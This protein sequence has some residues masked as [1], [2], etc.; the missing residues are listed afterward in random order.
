MYDSSLCDEEVIDID[1]T[2]FTW[3]LL[4]LILLII[5]LDYFFLQSNVMPIHEKNLVLKDGGK[6]L[7]YVVVMK[8]QLVIGKSV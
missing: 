1:H 8:K 5:F 4:L 7:H 6:V 3:E 2:A